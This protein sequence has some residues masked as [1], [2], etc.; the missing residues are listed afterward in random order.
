[1]QAKVKVIVAGPNY[2]MGEQLTT[3]IPQLLS[4]KFD[5]VFVLDDLSRDSSVQSIRD[6][7]ADV[8]VIEGQK[9]LGAA[10]NRNRIIDA[11]RTRGYSDDTII[12][13]IDS[14][15]T[16]VDK[17]SIPRTVVKLFDKYP[18][19][20]MIGG[21]VL[22]N[23]GTW[24]AFNYGP[25]PLLQWLSTGYIPLKIEE[26]SKSDPEKAK[27]MARKYSKVLDACP[28]IFDEPA[29]K[30]VG[31]LVENFVF[32]RLGLFAEVGGYDAALQY[33][34]TIDLARKLEKRGLDRIFDP[35]L[36]V[37]HLQIDNRGWHRNI[38]IAFAVFRLSLKGLVGR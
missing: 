25:L 30:K 12:V 33:C 27:K 7:F 17:Q 35:T 13:F 38:E 20:G 16:L 18:E 29:A 22:N 14:D 10:G 15:I 21:K 32:I 36:S 37:K 8:T 1:M 4:Q 31:W 2:N 26:I 3:L 6:N 28:N 23:D 24:S 34:E 19:C 11:L 5:G 9:N